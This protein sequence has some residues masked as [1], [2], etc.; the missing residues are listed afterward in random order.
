MCWPN[1][2]ISAAFILAPFAFICGAVLD[3]ISLVIL[4]YTKAPDHRKMVGDF[5][6]SAWGLTMFLLLADKRLPRYWAC[7]FVRQRWRA[8]YKDIQ[9]PFCQQWSTPWTSSYILNRLSG[10]STTLHSY[11]SSATGI[12]TFQ[13]HTLWG[14]T[15]AGLPL[16]INPGT[17]L[18]RSFLNV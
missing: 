12:P 16:N 14:A 11:A 2:A 3:L 4:H 13:R 5:G 1:C 15:L 17:H 9:E 10:E 6:V 7:A 18:L 8:R